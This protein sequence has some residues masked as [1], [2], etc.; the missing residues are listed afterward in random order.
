VRNIDRLDETEKIVLRR[1]RRDAV[2]IEELLDE[3]GL[4]AAGAIALTRGYCLGRVFR[5]PS[6]A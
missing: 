2:R 6:S 3:L 4:R 1:S 5:P